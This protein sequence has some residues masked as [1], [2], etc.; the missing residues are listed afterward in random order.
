VIHLFGVSCTYEIFIESK[1]NLPLLKREEPDVKREK[2]IAVIKILVSLIATGFIVA[3]LAWPDLPIDA[4]TYGL[5]GL[6]IV[7]WLSSLIESAKFPGGFE[8]KFRDLEDAGRMIT[9]SSDAT[10]EELTSKPSYLEIS[11]ADP[12]LAL[13]GLRIEIEKRVRALADKHQ[14]PSQRS[15][16]RLFEELRRHDILNTASMSGFQELIM[17]G[18]QAAHGAKVEQRVAEWAF[19]YGPNILAALDAKLEE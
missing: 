17:A 1:V 2:G 4:I 16:M 15:L 10:T 18:N 14:I 8:V 5:L 6:A 7:P 9:D 12:N 19:D 13:V 3:H 11:D